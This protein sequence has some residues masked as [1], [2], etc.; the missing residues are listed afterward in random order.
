MIQ[1]NLRNVLVILVV[2]IIGKITAGFI[3]Q[4]WDLKIPI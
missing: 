3:Y 1:V 2:V 4:K